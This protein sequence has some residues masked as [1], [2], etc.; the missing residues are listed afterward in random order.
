VSFFRVLTDR[1]SS[2]VELDGLIAIKVTDTYFVV[3]IVNMI[4]T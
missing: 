3:L 2:E 1:E 4:Q